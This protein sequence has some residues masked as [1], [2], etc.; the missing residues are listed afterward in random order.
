MKVG[1]NCCK[2]AINLNC[3][4]LIYIFELVHVVA[5]AIDM[6][7]VAPEDELSEEEVDQPNDVSMFD[8]ASDVENEDDAKKAAVYK[9]AC[10]KEENV[11][12]GER[13]TLRRRRAQEGRG[14]QRRKK[15]QHPRQ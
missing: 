9:A 1:K 5:G 15:M 4:A 12:A 10:E 2:L 14:A 8:A 6:A 13:R 11:C 3:K 7:N